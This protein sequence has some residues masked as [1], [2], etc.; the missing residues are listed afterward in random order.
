M[1]KYSVFT[2]DNNV[3]PSTAVNHI[4]DSDDTSKITVNGVFTKLY[5]DNL[6]LYTS[7]ISTDDFND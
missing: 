6:K 3:L 4:I 2:V 7:L 1:S 5:A